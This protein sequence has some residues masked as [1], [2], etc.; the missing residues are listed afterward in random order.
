MTR[1][2]LR[3]IH[4]SIGE[5]ELH[6]QDIHAIIDSDPEFQEA[7]RVS[8]KTGKKGSRRLS[9]EQLEENARRE[10]A[11]HASCPG[12]GKR[13]KPKK[14][15]DWKAEDPWKAPNRKDSRRKPP[16]VIINLPAKQHRKAN[17]E[18]TPVPVGEKWVHAGC[19]VF[20]RRDVYQCF[21]TVRDA[22]SKQMSA[23]F[24]GNWND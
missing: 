20:V 22:L 24:E 18:R 13:R 19:N 21:T 11:A 17:R 8:K 10:D 5:I 9:R 1:N 3:E 12:K 4:Q 6:L 16:Y 2:E 15:H 7:I 14:R 23:S